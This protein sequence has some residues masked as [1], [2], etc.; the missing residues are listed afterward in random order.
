M[1]GLDVYIDDYS[2]PS[3]LEPEL[4]RTLAQAR[5]LFNPPKTHVTA[6]GIVE[7][8]PDDV[9]GEAS[10]ADGAVMDDPVAGDDASANALPPVTAAE[11][12]APALEGHGIDANACEPRAVAE[13]ESDPVTSSRLIH[14]SDRR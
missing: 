5:Y 7:D 2:K 14:E 1:D 12:P 3:P 11:G 8:V 9:A 13:A 6:E 4:V 10:R